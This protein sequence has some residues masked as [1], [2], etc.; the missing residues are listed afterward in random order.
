MLATR[1]RERRSQRGVTMIELLIVMVITSTVLG[2]IAGAFFFMVRGSADAQERFLQNAAVQRITELWTKDVQSADPSGFYN[3]AATYPTGYVRDPRGVDERET[4]AAV[5]PPTSQ[6]A[7]RDTDATGVA[8][9]LD[10]VTFNW[11]LTSGQP[12]KSATWVLQNA[13]T[14]VQLLRRY[15]VGGVLKSEAVLAKR[16][17]PVAS[18][19]TPPSAL[20]VRGPSVASPSSFCP[21]DAYGVRAVCTLVIPALNADITVTRRVPDTTSATLPTGVPAPPVIF[22]HDNRYQY[23]NVRFYPTVGQPADQYRLTLRVDSPTGPVV[24]TKTVTVTTPVPSYYQVQFGAPSDTALRVETPLVNYWVTAEAHNSSGWSVPS[25]PYGPMNPQPVGPDAPTIQTATVGSDGC[26][27]VEWTHAANDGG[28]PLTGFRIW[29]YP[30]PTDTESFPGV[31]DPTVI[32]MPV[33]DQALPAATSYK[34]CVGLQPLNR[35]RFVVAD[36]NNIDIGWIS[37]PSGP[38]TPYTPGTRFVKAGASNGAKDCMDPA[39]PCG[40]IQ[41]AV[42]KATSGD[43]IAVGSG[44]FSSFHVSS[45]GVVV[46]GGYDPAKWLKTPIPSPLG[47]SYTF[48]NG[49]IPSNPTNSS[50]KTAISLRSLS[51]PTAIKNLAVGHLAD[52][53]ASTTSSGIDVIDSVQVV[54]IDAVNVVGGRASLNPT[55]IMVRGNSSVTVQSSWI[56]SGTAHPSASG[57]GAYGV[58]ALSGSTVSL[59][60]SSIVAQAGRPGADGSTGANASTADKGCAGSNGANAPNNSTG[61]TGATTQFGSGCSQAIAGG[62]GGN[63]SNGSNGGGA[64]NGLNG[65]TGGPSG[66][67]GA[68]GSGGTGYDTRGTNAAR[69]ITGSGGSGGTAGVS[70][71]SSAAFSAGDLVLGAGG[72]AG[73]PGSVGSAGGGG[74]GGGGGRSN[75]HW[76]GCWA[77]DSSPRAGGGGGKG[78]AAG[79]VPGSGGGGGSAG[80]ASVGVY[81]NGSTVTLTST[82]IKVLGGGV[83]GAGGPGGVG[84]AGG[85]GG[86]GGNGR[87]DEGA[88]GGGGGGGGGSG[89]GG[90]GGGGRGG[91]SAGIVQHGV[92]VSI[93]GVS[94]ELPGTAASG[95]AAGVPG[96]GGLGGAKGNRGLGPDNGADNSTGSNGSSGGTPAVGGSGT[97]GPLQ[98]IL[99]V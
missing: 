47:G 78:G 39:D 76:L 36:R 28:S 97:N 72:T 91:I 85:A 75:C 67:G 59:A 54:T 89:G 60:S 48:V 65:S 79:G 68:A 1:S 12:P 18:S 93:S 57:S 15:C 80:G 98:N 16:L 95:G 35:Y 44:S 62:N 71:T 73:L 7:C 30:S 22:A 88:G 46:E 19:S 69:G 92:T 90:G 3:P 17:E 42:D 31:E 5:V 32:S 64:M 37:N 82:A 49:G 51:A 29:A 81:A 38:T 21:G 4:N 99:S 87:T 74:G 77:G 94:Y 23:L 24:L 13:P 45:K 84:A 6:D 83:G 56:D 11:D 50:G 52:V 66:T 40:T 14:G 33:A 58:R 34:F 9:E 27:D 10:R 8:V 26:V 61:G 53:G 25:D 63:G 70:G 86:T 96:N 43:V 2:A 41:F 55:G 20:V